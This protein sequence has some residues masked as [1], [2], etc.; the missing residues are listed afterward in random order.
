MEKTGWKQKLIHEATEY[1][2]NFVYLAVFF[3]SFALYRRLI[4]AE[5]QISY[6]HYGVGVIEALILA[7]VILVGDAL[8]LGR[9]FEGRPLIYPTLY[10]AIVF[11]IFFGV[12][13]VIE[14]TI[15]GILHDQGLMEGINEL[16]SKGWDELLSRCLVIFIAFIPFFAFRELGEVM[17]EGKIGTLFFTKRKKG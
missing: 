8:H 5:H 15:G 14:H 9:G 16:M 13:S 6:F 12:F 10:K 4:L 1:W 7:K 17:G 3:C 2:V 11:T